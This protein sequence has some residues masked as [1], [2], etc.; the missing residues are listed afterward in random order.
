MWHS[1]AFNSDEHAGVGCGG[2]GDGVGA[3]RGQ[4]DQKPPGSILCKRA[5]L[6]SPLAPACPPRPQGPLIQLLLII[7]ESRDPSLLNQSL[8]QTSQV[9][10]KQPL[11]LLHSGPPGSLQGLLR[12]TDR[13]LESSSSSKI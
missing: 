12:K 13:P 6:P 7:D 10:R 3:A 1:T 9:S 4:V 11:P 2:H 8:K 5:S